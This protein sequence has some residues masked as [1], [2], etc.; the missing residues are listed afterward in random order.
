M[1]NVG[2]KRFYRSGKLSHGTQAALES[3]S[4]HLGPEAHAVDHQHGK[5]IAPTSACLN[6]PANTLCVGKE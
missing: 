3:Q 4:T 1:G 2:T 6:H 5:P